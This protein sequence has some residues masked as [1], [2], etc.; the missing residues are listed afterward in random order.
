[1]TSIQ[2]LVGKTLG[3]YQVVEHLGHGG[4]AEVYLGQQVNLERRVAIKVL[5]P[6]LAEE[7]GFVT[8]FQR[9]ARIVA[10]LRHP[11]IVQVYDFD[12]NEEHDIYYMVMEY[13]E[14][15][16]LKEQMAHAPFDPARAASIASAIAEALGY[17]HRRDMV[18]R[19]IKPANIMFTAE[20]QPVLADFGIAR[21][22]SLT[23]L[24][25][26]GAMVG[27]PA[28]MA[29][30]IGTGKEA[31][32][33]SDL[34]SLGVVLYEMLTGRPPFVAEIPMSLV[35][36]HIGEPV[37]APSQFVSG[38]PLKLEEIVLKAL[39]KQPEARYATAFDM[40]GALRQT[41][42]LETPTHVWETG[43]L[44]PS[45]GGRRTK[46]HELE[47]EEPLLRTWTGVPEGEDARRGRTRSGRARR[48]VFRG[49]LG[50][51]LVSV[52]LLL[53]LGAWANFGSEPPTLLTRIF[54]PDRQLTVE[55]QPVSTP[56]ATPRPANPTV[57]STPEG[58][59][60][61][62]LTP[63]TCTYRAEVLRVYHAARESALPPGSTVLAYITLRNGGVCAW[64]AGTRLAFVRGDALNTLNTLE[65]DT[66]PVGAQMQVL[67]PLKAPEEAGEYTAIWEVQR[68]DGQTI[69]GEIALELTTDPELP[70]P[71]ATAT[72]TPAATSTPTPPSS[73]VLGE[74]VLVSWRLEE[75]RDQ[76]T[77][78]VVI[79]VT[80]GTGEIRLYQ[81]SIRPDTA[82]LDGTVEFSG[83][84]CAAVSL[85][86][87][88]VSAEEVAL[89]EGLIPYPAP[90]TCR[91]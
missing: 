69:S 1:M 72:S 56:T 70:Q 48:S 58:V 51:L 79:T 17:A 25:A 28:Y 67:V 19:D 18:H 50:F 26:S 30:E 89:W 29:P 85:R 68:P 57:P 44:S 60:V 91:S 9:E 20:G 64:P 61:A 34:Y 53:G 73:L 5:H 23:N 87:I 10:T 80:G 37:P 13:I 43:P 88:A 47:L 2:F 46:S 31:S 11:N 90:E 78:R 83:R 76:W 62:N 4:M 6:F 42:D 39:A 15:A 84:R 12:H 24:T 65:L 33:A 66:L 38:L 22:M 74:P 8:R 82:L 49:V 54:N 81:D 21:M 52:L 36:K 14:G 77:G 71:T 45:S 55:A 86:I 32:G 63:G 40:A 16:T 41:M 75:E 3:K 27:T 7:D 35:M 59:S